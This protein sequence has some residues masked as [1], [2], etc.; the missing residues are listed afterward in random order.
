VLIVQENR[1]F[2]DFFATYPGADG[3]TSGRMGDE[4]I[5][6]KRV[7]LAEPC[8]F[9]HS[10]QGFIHD[11]NFGKMNGFG[12]E[13]GNHNCPG[14][15]ETKPYQYVDPAEIAP[16][17]LMARRFVLADH[18]FQTQGSGSF[19]AHQDL[20][21]GGTTIDSAQTVALIDF[22]SHLPWGC[23]AP[24]GTKTSLIA[25][26]ESGHHLRVEFH[27][28]PFPCTSAFPA[29]ASYTTLRD[30]LDDAGVTWKYYSPPTAPGAGN[31]WN[32]FDMIAAVRYGPEWQT[33]VTRNEK[34]ILGDV[35]T[36][37]L[38]AMSWVIPDAHNSDHPA[39]GDTGPSWVATVVNAIGESRYW[40]TTAIIV[41]WDDWGGFYDHVRPPFRDQWGG[42]GFRVPMLVISPYSRETASGEH[43]YISH[44]QYEF[45]SI[46]KFVEQ[47]W[48]LGSLG[49]TDARATS[50]LKCFDFTQHPRHFRPIPA[51]Y[52][53]GYFEHQRPS[54]EPV[55]TE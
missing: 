53:R 12:H 4:L 45:G 31:F 18:M 5:P 33:N 36:S 38:P 41:I 17:W 23:D 55:D 48:K 22:P 30:L 35:T 42:L 37:A 32:A 10:Y 26:K 40:K 9:G 44:T 25:P 19:T 11:Y 52:S 46:L 39:S 29:S 54:Y 28:G 6:L 47:N 49:T 43:G 14:K 8:D 27:R 7:H 20:I 21:R 24:T 51:K 1:S 13:G 15:A 3:T 16:Y 50:I 2:D 34:D